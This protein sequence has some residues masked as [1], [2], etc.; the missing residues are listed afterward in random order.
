MRRPLPRVFSALLVVMLAAFADANAQQPAQA[1]AA[2][3]RPARQPGA[4]P[5]PADADTLPDTLPDF[6]SAAHA[7]RVTPI[8]GLSRPFALAFLPDGNMLVTEREGHLRIVRN[9]V[10]DPKSIAGMPEVLDLQLKGLQDL[11]LHPRFTENR[12]IYFTYYKPKPG[13]KDVATAV[14]ARARWDGGYQL[15]DVKDLFVSDAWCATPSAARI[16]FD[17]DGHT[18]FMAIGVPIRLKRPNTAQ[19]EDSQNPGSDAGKILRLNDDGS[20]PADN[21][22]VGKAGYKPEIYALGIRN[23]LGLFIHP[24]TGELW[25]HENGPMGGDEI[26]IIKAGKNY[27]WPVVSF[28]RAYSGDPTGDTSGPLTADMNAP[29]M[30]APFL[31]WVPSIAPSGFLYYTGEKFDHW[32]GNLFVGGMR[33]MVLQ[34]IVLNAKGFPVTRE[35]LL[36]DLKQ[37]IRDVRQSPDGLIYVLTDENHGAILKLEPK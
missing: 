20:V 29:G 21:P 18:L 26:N 19:P 10:V 35:P 25:E 3:A 17:R 27:G 6:S 4:A 28:G 15:T 1:G 8:K 36:T 32:K 22:F 11:V 5:L 16:V 13:E 7:F 37:R 34:R 31:F 23:S 2:P 12:L 24:Q 30:E 14:L 9:G 33:G